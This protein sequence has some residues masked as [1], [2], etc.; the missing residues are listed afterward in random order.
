MTDRRALIDETIHW[1]FTMK[2]NM[3]SR[4][5]GDAWFA[6]TLHPCLGTPDDVEAEVVLRRFDGCLARK[7]FGSRWRNSRALWQRPWGALV[8]QHGAEGFHFHGLLA[9][10]QEWRTWVWLCSGSAWRAVAP[11]GSIRLDPLDRSLGWLGYA[12]RQLRP[13]HS[14]S[15]VVLPAV[16]DLRRLPFRHACESPGTTAA[17]PALPGASHA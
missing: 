13:G 15:L 5:P 14:T 11:F 16:N 7:L 10:P 12:T 17:R 2:A 1:L 4:R 9:V 3:E 8:G 6:A